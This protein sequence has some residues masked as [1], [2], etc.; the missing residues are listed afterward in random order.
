MKKEFEEPSDLLPEWGP[1]SKKYMGISKIVEKA[2]IPGARFDCVV[3]PMLANSNQPLPNVTVP[4]G[5]HVWEA[6]SDLS[7]FAYRVELEWKDQVY[8]DVSFSRVDDHTNLIRTEYVNNTEL[9]QNCV[10]NYYLAMEYPW[11]RMVT[12]ACD[13]TYSIKKMTE[14]D[15]I[16]F[17]TPRPYEHLMP[18][19]LHRGEFFDSLFLDGRGFG[20]RVRNFSPNRHVATFVFGEDAGD[21]VDVTIPATEAFDQ[22]S[23]R[24]QTTSDAKSVFHLTVLE[25]E[26]VFDGKV[27]FPASRQ[28]QMLSIP[29]V[30]SG[31]KNVKVQL[32]SEGGS[33][34]EFDFVAL[35]HAETPLKVELRQP[36]FIP[37]CKK[38]ENGYELRYAGVTDTFAFSTE[39]KEIRVREIPSGALEDALISRL[40][41]ADP[42]FDHVTETFT[43]AFTEKHSDD[44]FY[45]N[46]IAH[47]IFIPAGERHI[48]YA[49]VGDG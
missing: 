23:F 48:E 46:F 37:E 11:K 39:N 4:S 20:D 45:Q 38:N 24:Y 47:S 16:S 28:L 19:G 43:S 22:L 25:D 17:Q 18:D 41:Q 13:G 26:K 42:S 32:V 44:G 49:L 14:Y 31:K 12:V 5:Y 2:P 3:H 10:L 35:T 30:I 29:V 34:I 36:D 40:S 33:G 21:H 8:A 27:E 1:Y 15:A 7:C 9:D 6:A